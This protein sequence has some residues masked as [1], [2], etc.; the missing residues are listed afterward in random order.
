MNIFPPLS[1]KVISNG[2]TVTPSKKLGTASDGANLFS[3]SHDN[4]EKLQ[5]FVPS[6]TDS[7][8]KKLANHASPPPLYFHMLLPK[9]VV[10]AY[11]HQNNAVQIC[12]Y[13]SC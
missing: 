7:E 4:C 5:R 3:F 2:T 12:H 8:K 9:I 6:K 13:F 1:L 10:S 11:S